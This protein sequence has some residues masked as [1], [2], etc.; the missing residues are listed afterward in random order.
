MLVCEVARVREEILGCTL[1]KNSLALCE[2]SVRQHRGFDD[3][4]FCSHR[5]TEQ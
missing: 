3:I 2:E 1:G 5:I 4:P